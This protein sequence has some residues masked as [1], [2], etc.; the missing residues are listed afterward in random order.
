MQ[1]EF[2]YS[3]EELK[4]EVKSRR[5]GWFL[6]GFSLGWSSCLGFL[7]LVGWYMGID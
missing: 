2:F 5:L 7:Y 4:K 6:I 3:K 1:G